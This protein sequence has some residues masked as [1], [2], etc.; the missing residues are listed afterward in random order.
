M[1]HTPFCAAIALSALAACA[2][3]P[4][5]PTPGQPFFASVGAQ[6]SARERKIV[7]LLSG[8]DLAPA[9]VEAQALIAEEP[10]SAEAKV[11][12]AEME[13][14][15][16]TLLGT[17]NFDL[18]A[19]PGDTY[20]GL[21]ERYLHDGALAY[22]L[23][24]YNGA[25]PPTQ[26][27][28]GQVIQI[29]GSPMRAPGAEAA[30][31]RR[32]EHAVARAKAETPV[33]AA[34]KAPASD[35]PAPPKPAP[36][37][38]APPAPDK[39]APPAPEKSAPPAPAAKPPAE[40]AP[41]PHDPAKAASLRSDALV[42]MNKGDIGQAVVVLRQAAALDPDSAPIKADLERALRIQHG[43]QAPPAKP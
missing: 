24:R 35:K 14:D 25:N 34:D 28:P 26:P 20:A 42:L 12:L 11:L 6:P 21:A 17:L 15:P 3:Q 8:G 36:D 16:K 39:P 1:K 41:P 5:A 23:A 18:T 2:S 31:P 10:D 27:T 22:A 30:A 43:P 33:K 13:Q 29:P 40:P 7:D 38:T 37:K 4:P 32:R 19:K 9:K